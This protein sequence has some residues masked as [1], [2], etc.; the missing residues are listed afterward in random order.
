MII[1]ER[2]L[3]H[4]APINNTLWEDIKE[5]EEPSIVQQQSW[6][7]VFRYARLVSM[8]NR[9]ELSYPEDALNAFRGT[10]SV[11]SPTFEGANS[12]E[13]VLLI[14]RLTM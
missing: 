1:F 13:S 14:R 3:S 8:Y 5:P 4:G 10:M 7:D 2:L 9:R 12:S 6:P 11:L